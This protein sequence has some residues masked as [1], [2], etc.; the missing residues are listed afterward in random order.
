MAKSAYMQ[1]SK[2]K[3]KPSQLKNFFLTLLLLAVTGLVFLVVIFLYYARQVPDP[4]AIAA[5]RVS[6]ST[7]I[8]D[9][10]RESLLYDI[11][12][13]EKRTII[14]WEQIPQTVKDATLAAEDSDFYNHGGIDFRGIL[15]ALYKDLRNLD[16]SQGGS[17]I[18]QQ[19][20]KK[21]LLGDEKT[22]ARKVKEAV[23]SVQIERK[24]SKDEIFWMY[25]NQIPYGSNAYG[26]EA[27][28]QT[29]F[30]KPAKDLDIAEATLLAALPNAPSYYSPYGTNNNLS[31]AIDRRDLILGRMLNLGTITQ[32]E[33]DVAV[34]EFPEITTPEISF[35][36]PHFVIMVREYLV[37]KY[38]EDMVQNGGLRVYTTLDSELQKIAEETVKKYAEINTERYKANNAALVATDP[39]TGYILAMVGS[40]DYSGEAEPE[41]CI[42]GKTCK[43][44]GNF[45]VATASRQPGSSFKPF[46]YTLAFEKGF[47]DSTILF[48]LPTE[49]NPECS[50]SAT[51]TKDPSGLDCYNPQNYDGRFR[52]PVTMRQALSQSLNVPSVK[53][54]YL[55]GIEGTIDLAHKMGITTLNDRPRYG[56]SLV[57]GGGEVRLVDMVAAYG[58][59]ANDGIRT[60]QTFIQKVV[61]G[62][63][64]ILEEN[65]V[66]EERVLDAQ[67]ARLMSDVLSD[68]NARGP[69][70]GYNSSLYFADRQ[71]AAKTGTTQENRDGWLIGYTPSLAVGVWTGNNNNDSMTQQGAGLS[72]AG[73]MW[74]E[75]IARAL[76]GT[77]SEQFIKPNP[78]FADKVMLN[79]NYNGPDGIH[80]LLYYVNKDN[81]SGPIP[82]N[83]GKD[84]QSKN[85]EESVQRWVLGTGQSSN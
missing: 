26:I 47:A 15:R 18:T 77:P 45:N 41:G 59:L 34:S 50:S 38:G 66:Q 55:A 6:E 44:E 30:N 17:T 3:K 40:K 14:P 11:H 20:I 83:H 37:N 46:A 5:R 53:T 51:Q 42:P 61:T 75:F 79:G 69:V 60:P 35:P 76:A 63:G 54:L 49:F 68:N 24:F 73:P 80:S 48:D 82:E 22:I 9:N 23:L 39:K 21:S 57:L 70:F 8:Y 74:H 62:D 16:A 36:A 31:R 65:K 27:A 71:V 81:P 19:L 72:A 52:G 33:H 32:E 1:R 7:K 4:S 64:T 67:L 43:F 85:W 28:A 58:V 29:F 12:G 56:L 2:K 13:E 78:V 10:T 84:S 25:L